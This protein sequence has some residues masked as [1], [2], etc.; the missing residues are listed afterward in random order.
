[1]PPNMPSKNFKKFFVFV[2]ACAVMIGTG[3][4][5]LLREVFHVEYGSKHYLLV[6]GLSLPF[7]ILVYWLG[8]K[9]WPRSRNNTPS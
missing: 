3:L 6:N 5:L 9:I 2:V 4:S 8:L 1:M 7:M